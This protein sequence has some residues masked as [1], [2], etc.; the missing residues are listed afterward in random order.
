MP[1]THPGYGMPIGGVMATTGAIVPNAVGVDI[2][3]FAG[4]TEVKLTDGRDL[5]FLELIEEDK[6][7]KERMKMKLIQT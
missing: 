2:G 5:T 4:N 7:G 6:Q 1:D 3:C